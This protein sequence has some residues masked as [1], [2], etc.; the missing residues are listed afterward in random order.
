MTSSFLSSHFQLASS[1]VTTEAEQSGLH[2]GSFS[3]C[4][5]LQHK[6]EKLFMWLP[7]HR[8]RLH[9]TIYWS[10]WR[11]END[12]CM[13]CGR[14]WLKKRCT[15]CST[16]CLK[17]RRLLI[18]TGV[19]S[20]DTFICFQLVDPPASHLK[21]LN[22]SSITFWHPCFPDWAASACSTCR[23]DILQFL[24]VFIR[25]LGTQY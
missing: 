7:I 4:A 19:L 20:D 15:K 10:N 9:R 25:L 12:I 18:E 2:Y 1:Y 3:M 5:C 17:S 11:R 24:I 13:Q 22:I 6:G 23:V 21:D 16:C 8:E 14:T